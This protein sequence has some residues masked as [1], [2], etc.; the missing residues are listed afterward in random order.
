MNRTFT[1]H[2]PG[3]QTEERGESC[4]TENHISSLGPPRVWPLIGQASDTDR[5]HLEAPTEIEGYRCAG[6]VVGQ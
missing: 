2:V 4:R 3:N 5:C 1:Q 6:I